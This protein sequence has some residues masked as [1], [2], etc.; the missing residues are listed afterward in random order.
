MLGLHAGADDYLPKPCSPRELTARVEALV[1]RLERA[2]TASR[3]R[4]GPLEIDAASREVTL[5]GRPVELTR[6]EFDLLAT[7][8]SEPRRVFSRAELL[9]RVWGSRPEYQQESTVTEHVRRVRRKLAG[10]GPDPDW[11]RAVR[12]IGYRFEPPGAGEE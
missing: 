8:A 2:P 9:E 3:S 10:D 6:R 12:G 5:R 4:F 7:L 1:R 11:I